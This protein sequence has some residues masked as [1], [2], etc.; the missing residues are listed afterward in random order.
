MKRAR[1]RFLKGDILVVTHKIISK[2]EGQI[3]ALDQVLSANRS[4]P[5]S[6]A[7]PPGCARGRVGPG[8]G[9]ARGASAAQRA[10]HR[11][12]AR[13]GLRQQRRRRL[14]CRRRPQRGAAAARSRPVG[15]QDLWRIAAPP[16]VR[17]S[18]YHYRY[19]RSPVA[20]RT[21]G[22][23]DW[24]GRNE[25][26]SRLPRP[27]RSVWLFAARQPG[28]GGRRAGRHGW[29]GVRQAVAHAGVYYSRV[30]VRAGDADAVAT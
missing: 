12:A 24:R 27:A 21:G 20:R 23:G 7:P 30:R 3:V 8:T 4:P 17:H 16:G 5:E 10:H 29:A 15:P 13:L 1:L 26:L 28:S 22:G 14:Q 6:G 9:G 2:A 18:S 25:G 19:L 11:D